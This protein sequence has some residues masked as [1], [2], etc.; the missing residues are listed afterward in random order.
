MED[1]SGWGVLLTWMPVVN[2]TGYRV[3][4]VQHHLTNVLTGAM[5]SDPPIVANVT[6]VSAYMGSRGTVSVVDPYVLPNSQYTYSVEAL[7]AGATGATSSY[8]ML[9]I[10]NFR[11][12]P[13]TVPNAVPIQASVSGT[14]STTIPGQLGASGPQ[15]G[16]DVTWTWNVPG[17][18]LLYETS[19]EIVG[20]VPGIGTV[21]E[22][23]TV[24]TSGLPP[25]PPSLTLGVPSGMTVKF[26]VSFYAFP[27]P[28][29]I[30]PPEAACQTTTVPGSSSTYTP[31]TGP[32]T[33]TTTT[34]TPT[35]TTTQSGTPS[36]SSTTSGT[37]SSSS[38]AS[39]AAPTVPTNLQLQDMTVNYSWGVALQFTGVANAVGYRINR[40][41]TGSGKPAIVANVVDV[42]S[43]G[44]TQG[45]SVFVDPFV[46]PSTDYT[47]WVEA[48]FSD[49]SVSGPSTIGSVQ[50]GIFK[51][52]GTGF[53]PAAI[54]IQAAIS[55][56][57][58]VTLPGGY[59]SAGPMPGS[60]VTWTFGVPAPLFVYETSYEVAPP[61]GFGGGGSLDRTTIRVPFPPPSASG[62]VTL[63]RGVPQGFSVRFCVWVY[64]DPDPTKR[65][66]AEASCL[67]STVP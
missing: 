58:T 8:T 27:A 14:K 66:P 32:R 1:G 40:T 28:N 42:S 26:C 22:R 52:Q 54:P 39:G 49:G 10:G 2:A 9:T 56:T 38:T 17:L 34:K 53:G 62:T 55:G 41:I 3:T 12:D 44:N 4:R 63:T 51:V 15:Q 19:Y 37:P 45:A 67:I 47:Y 18:V 29:N 35:S 60:D 46:M 61:G 25:N 31:P 64:A 16:S 50:V 48:L 5:T 23:V 7:F 59:A 43:L 30:L 6:D 33:G 20:G 11:L 57:K 24:P 65:L 21:Y 13:G 36:T